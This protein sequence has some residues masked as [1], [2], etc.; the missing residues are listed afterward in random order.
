MQ[1]VSRD[2]QLPQLAGRR[3][4]KESIALTFDHERP[5]RP[6]L[7]A[8]MRTGRYGQPQRTINAIYCSNLN[9]E[10]WFATRSILIFVAV[11]G[12][13]CIFG[14]WDRPSNPVQLTSGTGARSSGKKLSFGSS[15]S[16]C[17]TSS[18]AIAA[19]ALY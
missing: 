11:W 4:N 9:R 13:P 2:Y 6:F 17:S 5:L 1:R 16:G 14:F 7:T 8:K 15:S 18:A 3:G 10:L 19:Q 12:Q